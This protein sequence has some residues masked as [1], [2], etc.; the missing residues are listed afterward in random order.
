MIFSEFSRIFTFSTPRGGGGVIRSFGRKLPRSEHSWKKTQYLRDKI[1]KKK[2]LVYKVP[3]TLYSNNMASG[4]L[5]PNQRWKPEP[6]GKMWEWTNGRILE[7]NDDVKNKRM[8]EFCKPNS[9]MR[10]WWLMSFMCAH[11][12]CRS[13]HNLFLTVLCHSLDCLIIW[14]KFC[15]GSSIM[16]FNEYLLQKMKLREFVEQYNNWGVLGGQDH[17]C[18]WCTWRP[19]SQLLCQISRW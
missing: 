9:T 11:S 13:C 7:T 1:L 18:G 17:V 10:Y 2:S 6:A 19:V 8:E 4:K 14:I 16:I 5:R 12:F 15:R 3:K